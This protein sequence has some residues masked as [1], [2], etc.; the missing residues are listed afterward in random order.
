MK[1]NKVRAL[2]VDRD[3]KQADIADELK[4]SR[5][6][7]SGVISGRWRSRRVV[8]CIARHLDMPVE[9][10]FPDYAA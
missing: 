7:V 5:S 4:L 10:L 8:E 6:H 9:R 3:I 2:M 1:L